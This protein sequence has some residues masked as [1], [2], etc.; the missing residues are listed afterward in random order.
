VHR[1]QTALKRTILLA[2]ITNVALFA[3]TGLVTTV[4]GTGSAGSAGI[5]GL[6]TSAQLNTPAGLC[7]D[8]AGNL[9]IADYGNNRV[10]RVDSVTGIMTL[11]AGNGDS[12]STGDG[13]PARLASLNGPTGLALDWGGNLY[14]SEFLGNRVRRVDAQ[15]GIITTVAGNGNAVSDPDGGPATAAGIQS[16]RGIVLDFTGNLYIAERY[17]VRR[18]DAA[19]GIITTALANRSGGAQSPSWLALDQSGNLLISDTGYPVI[20]RLN[21]VTGVIGGFAG[22]RAGTFEGDGV[23]ALSSSVGSL[24]VGIAVDP[25]GNGYLASSILYRLRRVD[26]VTG[27]VETVA[28][29]GLPSSFSP[30]GNPANVTSI[31]PQTVAIAPDGSVVFT[32]GARVRRI[33]LPSPWI[34]TA[35]LPYVNP[36]N[37]TPGQ[38]LTFGAMPKPIDGSGTPTGTVTFLDA[39]TGQTLGSAVLA[40]GVA[41]LTTT[42]PGPGTYHVVASYSG[43]SVFAASVSPETILTVGAGKAPTSLSL[44]STANPSVIGDS[45]SFAVG[46]TVPPNLQFTPTGTLQV[47]DA[48]TVVLTTPVSGTGVW[49]TLPLTAGTH[50]LSAVYSGDSNLLG[51]TSPVLNQVIQTGP[52]VTIASSAN[53]A[54]VGAPLTLTSTVTPAAATGVVEFVEYVYPAAITWGTATLVNGTAT[55]TFSALPAVSAG[56]H[57]IQAYYHGDS[58]YNSSYSAALSQQVGKAAASISLSSTM[59][60]SG[61]GTPF[62]INVTVAAPAGF[63]GLPTG[64]VQVLDGSASLGTVNLTNGVAQ[65][66][67]TFTTLGTHS[68]TA[69]YSGDAIFAGATSAPLSQVVKSTTAFYAYSTSQ[70]PS[71]VGSAVTFGALLTQT[72]ATGTVE[73]VD[74]LSTPP[75]SLGIATVVNGTVSL[76]TSSLA[77]GTHTINLIY[78][79]DANF[80]GVTGS[81]S[82]VVKLASTLVLTAAPTAMFGQAV[83]VTANVTPA[84]AT[85]SVQLFDGPTILGTVVLSNG[86]AVLSIPSLAAGTH[87]IGA[88][89]FGDATYAGANGSNVTVTVTKATPSISV[90]SSQ[91]PAPNGQAVTFTV[92]LTPATTTGSVQ[93]LDGS[94]VLA[95][96]G[97]GATTASVTLGVGNHS[98]TAVY[99]GDANFN[100]A[101]SAAV[102]QLVTTTTTTTVSADLPNATYGQTVRLTAAVA[103]APTGGTVQFLD[104]GTALG[105]VTVQSGAASLSVSTFSVGIHSITAVFSGDGA[106]YLGNT[107]AALTETVGKTATTAAL[108]A[109]PNPAMAGQ[110]VT[111]TAAVSPATATGT[112]QFLDGATVL[113]TVPVSNG[114]ASL[115]TSTLSAG[116]HSLTVAYSGDA[117]NLPSTSAVVIETVNKAATTST[118]T[119]SPNPATVSQ[120]VTLSA[121][122]SPSTA[123]GT[124]QFFD[125]ATNLGTVPVSSGAASLSTSTLAAGSHSLTVVYSGDATNSPSTSAAVALSVT[126]AAT[127]STLIASPNPATAGQSVTLTAAVSPATATGTVQFFDGAT[128]LGTVPVSNGAAS[129]STSTLVVGSHSLTVAYSGDATNSPST[130]TVVTVSVSKVTTT[131]TLTTSPNP[132]TV[133]QPVTLTAAV[134]PATATGTVQFLDGATVLGTFPVNSGAASLST[135]TLSAGSHS[136]SVVYSGDATNSPSTSGVVTATVNKTAT[137]TTLAASPNPAAAGQSVTL[138]AAVSPATATGTV[139]FFDGATSLGTATVSNGAATLSTFAL[140][141]GSHSLTVAYSG[142]ATYAASTSSAVAETVNKAA[143]TASLSVS[144]N[145][146]TV[147]QAVTLSA[148]VSP[149]TATGTVQFFDGATSLGT[150]TSSNGTA[151]LSTSALSAGS[152]SLTVVYSGDATYSASTSAVVTETV[153]KAATTASLAASPNPAATG[154]SVTLSAAVSPSTATGT[155]Q[156]SDGATSLATVPV[157][158]GAAAFSTSALSAGSHSLTV[159]YSGDAAYS[160]STSAVVTETVNKAATTATLSASPNPASVGQSVTLSATVSPATATGTLQFF[161]GATSLGTVTV[162]NG[163][164]LLSTSALAAGSHS[165]TVAYSGDAANSASTSAVFT[166]TI[167]KAATT[168]TLAASPN[169][170]TVGQSVTLSATVSPAT[171]TGT[172]QFFDGATSL[173][174]VTVSNGAASLSTSALA[175]GSHSLTVA[176]S[177]DAANSAS[178]STVL[179][180]TVNKAATTATLTS[181][182]NPS[183]SGQAVTFT[184]QVSPSAATGSVQFKDGTTLLGAVTVSGGSALLAV[185]SLSVGTHSITAV[186]GGD[187]N[188]TGSTST[189]LTQTV[190]VAPPG[191]PTNLTATPKSTNQIT[192]AWTSSPTGGV[193]YNVYSSTTS[194]F[195]PSAGNRIAAGVSATSYSHNGLSPATTHYYVVTAQSSAGESTPSN[196]AGATT[197]A[198]GSACHVVYTVTTQWD[199]GFGTAITITNTGNKSFDNWK[200]TWTWGG[201][202][203]IT[204]AWNSTYTQTGPSA[205][206][207]NVS[208]NKNIAAGATLSGMGFNASYSG[209]NT[210]PTAFYVNGTLCQ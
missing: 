52:T 130:S 72:S 107:S 145:P 171:A 17:D 116:S 132:A 66:P 194:G 111:L 71:V 19:T 55:L 205:S 158:N 94:T 81:I 192:L 76:T 69:V 86:T 150:A 167:N 30:D 138:S 119:A 56:T 157:S 65:F 35:T 173:G 103:P 163:A 155:M 28:G 117:T 166:E 104:G 144:P 70:S 180:E 146:A 46:I 122:V 4:A 79:G 54:T 3:G 127:T 62:S 139:Q 162:S 91:N 42:A 50:P 174:T 45:L 80:V 164:A 2:L 161:D 131:S 101:T 84:A 148:A 110:S 184:S 187:T 203:Q 198:N 9:Y 172:V 100:G 204:Q 141:A 36:L 87:A 57:A 26:V 181:S 40:T 49:F 13:G 188:Y 22:D 200:L 95:N 29:N 185:S 37:T 93:L 121:A 178:T 202:Q 44:T 74:S 47:M 41:M 1:L 159:T 105:T 206:L 147:S 33:S 15:T 160:A 11:S 179:S 129:L 196:Q 124:M 197:L 142:D 85:G 170:A 207:V 20:M 183:V 82:Q 27:I 5:G 99:S 59:N 48:G 193:T 88:A 58:H 96:L 60:P 175:T 109:S 34:Y 201:N 140:S 7:Y 63:S 152:H 168:A 113:G 77:L 151:A 98:V 90:S 51:S 134:L 12:A 208:Y 123:A 92:A 195:T 191:A 156:F 126:K 112:V 137:T 165:L 177:G 118:L 186:Y 102:S 136:L 8:G 209:T 189:A 67:I 61:V 210:A 21:L 106:G 190:T 25:S 89:Y 120:A 125:G 114:A 182:L 31:T 14:I 16:P 176:Y 149:A 73:F 78:S 68:L 75:L 153:N 143:T 32:D 108:A 38:T 133:G 115:S 43:D 128:S 64:S 135:S 169:P 6:A 199:V 23:S 53:P 97:V 39:S 10:V 18:V 154:Q 83:Q 24:P